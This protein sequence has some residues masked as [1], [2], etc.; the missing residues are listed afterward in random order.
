MTTEEFRKTWLPLGA[1][2]YRVAFRLLEDE[3]EAKDAVQDLFVKLLG[4]GDKL[5]KVL[6][7]KAYA[8]TLMRNLCIDRIRAAKKLYSVECGMDDPKVGFL[9]VEPDV[10]ASKEKLRRVLAIIQGLPDRQREVLRQR[11]FEE[12]SYEEISRDTGLIENNLRVILSMARRNIRREYEK[13]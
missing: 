12:K 6:N 8:V 2:L 10:I 13:Y 1:P 4:S 3:D 9:P 11:I 5:D 7:P